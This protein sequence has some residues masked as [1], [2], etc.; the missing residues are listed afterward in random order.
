M[1]RN[2]APEERVG[3]QVMS[4]SSDKSCAVLAA[5]PQTRT[6]WVETIVE[7]LHIRPTL[8][9]ERE[10][11]KL[12]YSHAGIVWGLAKLAPHVFAQ[13]QA[14]VLCDADVSWSYMQTQGRL[15]TAIGRHTLERTQPKWEFCST[16]SAKLTARLPKHLL[17][18]PA[19]R[20]HRQPMLKVLPTSR[21]DAVVLGGVDDLWPKDEL[22]ANVD[23]EWL[24]PQ[25]DEVITS[26]RT[27][28][29]RA[30]TALHAQSIREVL[31]SM[32]CEYEG[33]FIE[34]ALAFCQELE[35]QFVQHWFRV[36]SP[37]F[38]PH[39]RANLPQVMLQ[40]VAGEALCSAADLTS[41]PE[42]N[43]QTVEQTGVLMSA[44][45]RDVEHARMLCINQNL[46]VDVETGNQYQRADNGWVQLPETIPPPALELFPDAPSIEPAQLRYRRLMWF[47]TAVSEATVKEQATIAST[48]DTQEDAPHESEQTGAESDALE[49]EHI[50]LWPNALPRELVLDRTGTYPLLSMTAWLGMPQDDVMATAR[51]AREIVTQWIREHGFEVDADALSQSVQ[52][53]CGELMHDTDGHTAWAWRI[54][55]RLQLAQ[56]AALRIDLTLMVQERVIFGMRVSQVRMRADAPPPPACIPDV[57]AHLVSGLPVQFDGTGV[58]TRPAF[59]DPT[60]VD[61]LVAGLVDPRRDLPAVLL[62]RPQDAKQW[63]PG[64]LGMASVHE[65][66]APARSVLE[67]KLG[68]A[69][70]LRDG[71]AAIYFGGFTLRADPFCVIRLPE[72]EPLAAA[73][74]ELG[75]W[76][77]GAER[78]DR[79]APEFAHVREAIV[80]MRVES[81]VAKTREAAKSVQEERDR[82]EHALSESTARAQALEAGLREARERA[83]Q[84]ETEIIALRRERDQARDDFRAIR[85]RLEATTPSANESVM[86]PEDQSPLP[87]MDYP[88]SWDDLETFVELYC[89]AAVVLTAKAARAARASRFVNIP[90]A[91]RA[92]HFLAT[93][94]VPMRRRD[95]HDERPRLA[96]QQE[97]AELG[98]EISNTGTAISQARYAK[99]YQVKHEGVKYRLDLHMKRR[100]SKD[101]PWNFRLYFAWDADKQRVIVGSLPDHLTS[102]LT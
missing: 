94:Y 89:G 76:S 40:A 37:M 47:A 90:F 11:R 22:V 52:G 45:V 67:K 23:S 19:A 24:L 10:V 18:I 36:R 97:L 3:E 87:A 62:S 84:L 60:G 80:A 57:V 26:G 17:A 31:D 85:H 21:A 12:L 29:L 32:R 75:A 101:S 64:L 14:S 7:G 34:P 65:L 46:F 20:I 73:I 98:V 95:P 56:G 9:S 81:A 71:Q 88:D 39:T 83:A 43:A 82:Y 96:Y 33:P 27:V 49:H 8:N 28:L 50:R 63:Q 41:D 93:H 102:R 100:A 54:E 1:E 5:L 79:R 48:R 77:V 78:G 51:R 38:T 25:L 30:N 66:D 72:S 99:E 70:T 86:A 15:L 92:L 6:A 35:T 4:A 53:G 58:V 13:P 42:A 61:D 55:D 16:A 44:M 91:Y 74:R 59:I 69:L 2:E 68:Q